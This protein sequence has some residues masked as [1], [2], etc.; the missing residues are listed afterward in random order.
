LLLAHLT[1]NRQQITRSAVSAIAYPIVI[2][3]AFGRASHYRGMQLVCRYIMESREY[4]PPLAHNFYQMFERDFF[5]AKCV[6]AHNVIKIILK[7]KQSKA[8]MA[9]KWM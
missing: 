9:E 1:S 6:P 2:G 7:V 3:S 5:H 8:R 4:V